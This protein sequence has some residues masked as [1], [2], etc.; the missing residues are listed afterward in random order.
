MHNTELFKIEDEVLG[1]WQERKI[2]HKVMEK[3]KGKKKFFFLEGP[4]YANGELHM[5]HVR[6]YTRKDAVLRYKWMRGF[7]VFNRA[8]FDVHGL[9]TENKAERQLQLTSKKDI[10]TKIGVDRFLATCIELYKGH[11]SQQ[12]SDAKRYGVWMDFDNAYNPASPDYINKSWGVFKA[13][14]DKGLV[15]KAIQVMPYCIHCGTVLA[16]GPEVEEQEDTD[17]SVYVAFKINAKKSKPKIQLGDKNVYLL[18]WTTTPWTLPANMA[19]AVNP[20][21]RYVRVQVESRELIMAKDRLEPVM[22]LLDHPAI[23]LD[24]FYGSQLEGIFYESPLEE[25]MPKQKE[26]RKYHRPLFSEEM[27]SLDDGTGIIHIAPAYGPEDFAIAKANKIPVL[28]I[29]DQDGRYNSDAGKYFGKALIHEANREIEAEL[30]ANGHMVYKSSVRHNYPHC[31]RCHEK[32]VYLPTEQ[33][34]IKVSKL[35]N[36]IRKV[37]EKID[38]HPKDMKDWFV[39]SIEEAPDWAISRQRYWDIPIPI[40]VCEQCGEKKAIGSF[41]DL[42][43]ESAMEH[44]LFTSEN[45]HKPFIDEVEFKCEKCGSKMHRVKDVFDVWYDSGVA[46]TASL[47]PEEFR[48]NFSKA[49]VTEGPDQI[50][51]W[52]ATL[53]KTAVAAYGKTPYRTVVMQGWVVDEKGEAMHKSK[54]NYVTAHELINKYSMDATRAFMLSHIPHEILKFSHREIEDMQGMLI[55][56]QNISN[57]VNDYSSA[58]KYTPRKVRKYRT[59]SSLDPQDAWI[60][61][62]LNS[63]I[64]DATE[65]F[66]NYEIQNAVNAITAFVVEDFSRFYLKLAKKKILDSTKAKAKA[67]I[68]LINNIMYNTILVLAPVAPFLSEKLYI[69]HYKAS[70]SVFLDRWPKYNDDLINHDLE[71]DFAVATETIT[72]ILSSR[73]K[74]GV[75]L[76]WPIV[77][78]TVEL[79][80]EGNF[81]SAERMANI[82]EEYTNTKK[83]I[84]KISKGAKESVVPNFAKLGPAFKAN[85]QA[86]AEALKGANAEE[87]RKSVELSGYY[88]LHTSSGPAEIKSEHFNIIQSIE[89]SDAIHF[90]YGKVTVDK[91]MN[92]ELKDEALLREFERR[93]QMMRKEYNLK[94]ADKIRLGYVAGGEIGEAVSNSIPRLRKSLNAPNIKPQLI[95]QGLSQDFEIEGETV[96]IS[97]AKAD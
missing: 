67:T 7:D 50:R 63:V 81:N 19:V 29:V 18:I 23:I 22:Q 15:Y 66:E 58:I 30:H 13:I 62:R 86:V 25:Q 12:I 93:V 60:L 88:Q 27:V 17:P 3:N 45:L 39:G 92:K 14:Y 40:W 33:W 75:K 34:F 73:E 51:G 68:D 32:L 31:W 85:A 35:K 72:A 44:M 28:S 52:F 38:W 55:T 20:K 78:A 16:K 56:L 61:S 89:E 82:I 47:T 90:K 6:G 24:E 94:K 42:K 43:K 77:S 21:A 74:A 8:G 59:A 57:L 83:L 36:K 5:G 80:S 91:T 79:K 97:I 49:F 9:P 46:H 1:Y 87:L 64:R 54:G 69:E 95:T 65:G 11:M 41:A 84:L 70:E 53:M 71:G 48:D 4:P 96:K 37:S 26:M 76:R 2:L 10:E